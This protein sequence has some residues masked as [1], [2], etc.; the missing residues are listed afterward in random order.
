M[1]LH[2][3]Y[4]LVGQTGFVFH[5]QVGT[6]V[7]ALRDVLL[8]R[9][10]PGQSSPDPAPFPDDSLIGRARNQEIRQLREQI[11]HEGVRHHQ[12]P[13]F[14]IGEASRV[15]LHG[16]H[17]LGPAAVQDGAEDG[18][19]QHQSG[20]DADHGHQQ[21][22]VHGRAGR[23]RALLGEEIGG[24]HAGVV[25]SRHGPAHE[26]RAGQ[27]DHEVVAVARAPEQELGVQGDHAQ[28]M[29]HHDGNGEQHRVVAQLGAHFHGFHARVVHGTDAGGHQQGAA[30]QLALV[31]LRATHDCQ[32]QGAADDGGHNGHRGDHGVVG[33]LDRQGEGQHA[34]EVHGPDA[35]AHGQGTGPQPD[36]AGLPGLHGAD[37]LGHVESGIARHGGDSEGQ[38]NQP[39]VVTAVQ[40]RGWSVGPIHEAPKAHGPPPLMSPPLTVFRRLSPGP[41]GPFPGR[42]GI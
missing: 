20:H 41:F 9:D 34:E 8:G 42:G 26:P 31:D 36:P 27:L 40:G 10:L 21:G 19:G 22:G 5:P 13:V 4:P 16:L 23:G 25:H 29:S 14:V 33:H 15:A 11:P 7:A 17:H 24:G 2:R 3:G 37:P 39:R 1:L 12:L 32:G 38:Q 6:R 35:D 30:P 28:E 18:D